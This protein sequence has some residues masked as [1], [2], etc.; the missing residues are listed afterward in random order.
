MLLSFPF[1]FHWQ[2]SQDSYHNYYYYYYY[3]YY[4]FT[5][6]CP[7]LPGWAGTRRNIHPPTISLSWS[8]SNLYQLLPSNTIHSILPVQITCLAIFL[9]NLSPRPLWS[10]SWSGALHAPYISSP[11]QCLLFATHVHTIAACFAVVPR[12]YHQDSYLKTSSNF[13]HTTHMHSAVY[14]MAQCLSLICRYYSL[15]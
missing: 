5:A 10:T 12:L 7:G 1:P 3:Y 13:Y 9:H 2:L 15:L 4:N 11:N 8:S 6:L 14:G